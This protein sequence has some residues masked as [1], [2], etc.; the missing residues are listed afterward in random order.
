[1]KQGQK[2]KPLMLILL[3][4]IPVL[5]AAV[6]GVLIGIGIIKLPGAKK[7]PEVVASKNYSESP[8]PAMKKE[9]IKTIIDPPGTPLVAKKPVV[10][11]DP[12]QVDLDKGAKQIAKVWANMDASKLKPIAEGYKIPELARVMVKLPPEKSAELLSELDAD[13]ATKVSREIEKIS[14]LVPAAPPG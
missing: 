9:E 13:L 11:V 7:K 10:K 1:M 2:K 6:V 4:G 8:E 5:A 14:S 3:I 12:V